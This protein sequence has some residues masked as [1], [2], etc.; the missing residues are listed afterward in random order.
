GMGSF[1]QVRSISALMILALLGGCRGYIV[2]RVKPRSDLVA[3]HLSRYG[4]SG[5]P[6]QCVEA[7]LT[8]DLDVWQLR[9]FHEL[10]SRLN[11]GGSNPATFNPW[12]LVYVAGLVR[13]AEV[14]QHVQEALQACQLPTAPP[15]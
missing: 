5:E 6:A 4:I 2:D 3:P 1:R 10:A 7:R 12:D 11:A 15:A 14:A 9:Q 8:K 13:D